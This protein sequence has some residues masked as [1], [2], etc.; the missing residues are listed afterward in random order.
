M[1]LSKKEQL[2]SAD[3]LCDSKHKLNT[4]NKQIPL[5]V[6]SEIERKGLTIKS[7]YDIYKYKTQIT[8]HGIC[9]VLSQKGRLDNYKCL[10]LNKNQSIGIRWIAI[11]RLKKREI[12][13]KLRY[14]GWSNVDSSTELFPSK[15][16]RYSSR[17]E[18]I[19]Q[20]IEWNKE[21]QRLDKSLFFGD[22]SIY[23]GYYYSWYACCDMHIN[24]IYA[25]N[26]D[27][28]IEQLAGKTMSEI[29][30]HIAEV[31]A[32]KAEERRKWKAEYERNEAERKRKQAEIAAKL[33]AE[34]EQ[35][36][37]GTTTDKVE[38]DTIFYVIRRD[39]SDGYRLVRY[40]MDSRKAFPCR[41]DG[42]PSW[43]E[44]KL[45]NAKNKAIPCYIPK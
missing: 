29:N 20:C 9:E 32:E 30:T 27:K 3:A 4:T 44:D 14:F 8:L 41:E 25:K 43:C 22:Y 11:D 38:K 16:K 1:A 40:K 26:V 42:S 24:G 2:F 33:K 18:A 6:V 19:N 35:N 17:E 37:I 5:S 21:L 12:V 31:E 10:T 34:L 28:V 15:C 13:N 45:P 39:Y 36:Y 23:I 7:G